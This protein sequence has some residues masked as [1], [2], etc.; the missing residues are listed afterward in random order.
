MATN[1][2][3]HWVCWWHEGEWGHKLS[4]TQ[5][6]SL[7]RPLPAPPPLPRDGLT[8]YRGGVG[9]ASYNTACVCPRL[10]ASLLVCFYCVSVFFLSVH[11][12][13]PRCRFLIKTRE[14]LRHER[15]V[16]RPFEEMSKSK[17][18]K[19]DLSSPFYPTWKVKMNFPQDDTQCVPG[20]L[21][22]VSLKSHDRFMSK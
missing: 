6:H 2:W 13:S 12:P 19:N 21:W 4:T 17:T 8:H 7:I 20:V 14:A 3:S 9:G 1:W 22:E 18:K 15:R 11:H 10:L 5:L 16:S